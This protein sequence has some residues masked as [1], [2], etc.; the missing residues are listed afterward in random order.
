MRGSTLPEIGPSL[1]GS[2]M[3]RNGSVSSLLLNSISLRR[4]LFH[5]QVLS[6]ELL[7][8]KTIGYTEAIALLERVPLDV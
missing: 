8:K 7:E 1:K 5:L 6:I 3:K 4:F 2:P